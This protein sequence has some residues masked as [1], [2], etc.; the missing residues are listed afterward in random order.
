MRK[1]MRILIPVAGLASALILFPALTSPASAPAPRAQ[2]ASTYLATPVTV[3]LNPYGLAPLAALAEFTTQFPCNVMVKVQGDIPV[4]KDFQDNS[5]S[6][7]I[8]IV[9]LYPG[10]INSV[11]LTLYRHHGNPEVQTLLIQTAPLPDWFPSISID[12][13]NL[14]F[15]EPGFNVCDFAHTTGGGVI[16]DPYIFDAEGQVRA[17]FDFSSMPGQ[18]F[19]FERLADGNFVFGWGPSIYEMDIMGK[20]QRQLSFPGYGFHH[21][22]RELPDGNLIACVNKAGT[23]IINSTGVVNS[24]EDRM[25]EIN[26]ATGAIVNEWDMRAILDVSRNEV[27]NNTGDWFHMNGVWYSAADDCFII[28]GRHQGV[29]KVTRDNKLKWILAGHDGWGNSGWDGTGPSPTPYLLT[30]VDANGNPEPD[31]VQAGEAPA[32]DFDWT[33]GQHCPSLLPN[34]NLLCFDNGFRRWFQGSS[35]YYSRGAEFAINEKVMT[36]GLVWQFGQDRGENMYSTII[37]SCDRLPATGNRLISPGIVQIPPGS[38]DLCYS[39]M[40][41]VTYP[42]NQVV[43]QATSTFKNLLSGTAANGGFDLTYRSHRIPS[44]YP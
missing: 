24:Q 39:Q 3:T 16:V 32:P 4:T 37:S 27:I 31:I 12:T 44:L 9:G 33:W 26:R 11:L 43:F 1:R 7:A 41:E 38:L 10:Q 34:G 2:A 40:I 6:H 15:M 42:G 36:A 8:P 22:I 25:I 18:A 30:A 20:I 17:Y 35:G 23:Q 14:A 13:E 29:I 21:D 5:T 19:P 28:S